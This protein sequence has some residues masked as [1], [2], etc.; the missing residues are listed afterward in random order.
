MMARAPD[1]AEEKNVSWFDWS[2]AIELSQDGRQLLF[3][4]GGR[5]GA[6]ALY[7]RPTDG[8]SPAVLVG[9][10]V[11]GGGNAE[12]SPE[13]K[14]VLILR[15]S[16]PREL[17]L[18]PTGPGESKSIQLQGVEPQSCGVWHEQ[19]VLTDGH[20]VVFCGREAGRPARSWLQD[21]R[22][23]RPRPITPE[24]QFVEAVSPD[25]SL[26]L[27]RNGEG[28]LVLYPIEGGQPRLATGPPETGS[29][30]TWSADG[31][32][33]FVRDAKVSDGL[34]ARIFRRDLTTGG[35]ELWKEVRPPDQAGLVDFY[36]IVSADSRAYACSLARSLSSLY[37]V[38][39]LK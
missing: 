7:V 19:F 15:D 23:G 32:S 27:G 2:Y 29:I 8:S 26:A 4:E 12:F 3:Y 22:G 5:G 39:G 37:L 33:L 13:A 9:D 35:R 31:K 18:V 10:L 34:A 17:L 30:V 20:R 24:G 16:S 36:C 11:N 38:E 6:Y 1:A 28:R 21:V 25:G 14:S